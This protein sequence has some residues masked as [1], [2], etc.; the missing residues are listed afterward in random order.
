LKK[1]L[2]D[3]NVTVLEPQNFDIGQA[4]QTVVTVEQCIQIS[5]NRDD[6]VSPNFMKSPRPSHTMCGVGSGAR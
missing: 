1:L 3:Q 5:R 4:V 2:A 6:T